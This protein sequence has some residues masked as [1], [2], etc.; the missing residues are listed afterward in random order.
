MGN[1]DEL[2]SSLSSQVGGSHYKEF[3]IQPVEFCFL[4][5]IPYLEATTIKY[6]CRWR[7]KNGIEDL[8]KAK[9]FIDLL[10]ELEENYGEHTEYSEPVQMGI[11]FSDGDW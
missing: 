6:L 3:K 2:L 7:R 5:K 10:I 1:K 9:H 11:D 4:N 8:L